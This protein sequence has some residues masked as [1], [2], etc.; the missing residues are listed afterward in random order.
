MDKVSELESHLHQERSAH[1]ETKQKLLKLEHQVSTKKA[2]FYHEDLSMF[3]PKFAV[4]LSR[5][6]GRERMEVEPE[7][8]KEDRSILENEIKKLNQKLEEAKT[9]SADGCPRSV[10]TT[11]T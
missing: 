7:S 5:V 10:R 6:V 4:L 3:L 11:R 8:A 9:E 1:E 2:S